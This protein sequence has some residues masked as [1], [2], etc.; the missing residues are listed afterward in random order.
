MFTNQLS[1][2]GLFLKEQESAH[3]VVK[4]HKKEFPEFIKM[5][6]QQYADNKDSDQLNKLMVV[7]YENQK[8]LPEMIQESAKGTKALN[9]LNE[10]F[11]DNHEKFL[12]IGDRQKEQQ[13]DLVD[14]H[15]AINLL[16]NRQYIKKIILLALVLVLAL[17]DIALFIRRITRF[18]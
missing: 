3:L 10:R 15:Q 4:R 8:V 2:R 13:A 18:F 11:L 1:Q 9:D 7:D 6:K 12:Q 14:T 16:T 17:I 5:N